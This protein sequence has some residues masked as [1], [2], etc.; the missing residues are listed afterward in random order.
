MVKD[1]MT[2]WTHT[3]EIAFEKQIAVLEE[4]KLQA[5]PG[6]DEDFGYCLALDAICK[7]HDEI[8]CKYMPAKTKATVDI[9]ISALIQIIKEI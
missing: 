3:A 7:M 2:N 9:L 4:K 6:S 5:V 8:A 1:E